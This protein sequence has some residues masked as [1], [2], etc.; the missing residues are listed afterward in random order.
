MNL[1][2]LKSFLMKSLKNPKISIRDW[3]KAPRKHGI[4]LKFL[5]YEQKKFLFENEYLKFVS[6]NKNSISAIFYIFFQEQLRKDERMSI[7]NPFSETITNR[8]QLNK[9]AQFIDW[10]CAICETG[11]KSSMI[12]YSPANF[13]CNICREV[14]H[15][16]KRID[17]RIKN[18]SLKFT[19]KCKSI[20]TTDQTK[21]LKF[22]QKKERSRL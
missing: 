18:N 7:Y 13:L 17:S 3:G 20:L 14:H 9:D 8:H 11:I 5:T 21:F 16:S 19:E 1:K 10:T 2:V 4:M 12:N 22:I 15:N 6:R